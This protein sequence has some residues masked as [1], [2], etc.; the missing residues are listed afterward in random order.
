MINHTRLDVIMASQHLAPLSDSL[1]LSLL[2]LC[3][4]C[5]VEQ[6]VMDQ[7]ITGEVKINLLLRSLVFKS[8][9]TLPGLPNLR[10]RGKQRS[11]GFPLRIFCLD[12]AVLCRHNRGI[13]VA[14]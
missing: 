3:E 7:W 11:I 4:T 6:L 13:L 9:D 10:L 5:P 14:V 2:D 12:Q 1:R 8:L